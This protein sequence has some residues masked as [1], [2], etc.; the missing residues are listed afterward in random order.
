MA[1]MKPIELPEELK[2]H[3][4]TEQELT[5]LNEPQRA[6]AKDWNVMKRQVEWTVYHV[7]EVHNIMVDHDK[8]LE[9]LWFWF[10]LIT[11]LT[12][13]GGTLVGLIIWAVKSSAGGGGH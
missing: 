2:R 3:N 1:D 8:K 12:G 4:L 7:V 10:K 6:I 5:P 13:G 9:D 11:L